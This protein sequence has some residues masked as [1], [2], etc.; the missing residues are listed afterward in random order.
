MY[1]TTFDYTLKNRIETDMLQQILRIVYTEKVREEEGG[2][3]GVSVSG[4]ISNYPKGQS[5]FQIYF[6]TEPAKADYLNKIVH[7][8][9]QDMAK[10]GPR[11]VDFDKVKEYMLKKQQENEQE[12]SYWQNA[13]LEYYRQNTNSYTDYV[14]TLNAV[15]PADIR[16]KVQ[17]LL[18]AKNVIEVIMTGVK[19]D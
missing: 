11:E 15:T 10:E 18:D 7:Q 4:S 3:Y 16:K 17:D 5:M 14:K 8:V 19:E 9:I 2:T 6:E 1:W 12:N 13:I